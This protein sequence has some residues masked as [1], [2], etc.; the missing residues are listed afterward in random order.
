MI[1]LHHAG[2]I[3]FKPVKFHFNMLELKRPAWSTS[4]IDIKGFVEVVEPWSNLVLQLRVINLAEAEVERNEI[5][6]HNDN[7]LKLLVKQ[8]E[9][10]NK[11]LITQNF[12]G[13]KALTMYD[14]A[15][16]V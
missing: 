3:N 5:L 1:H 11:R 12:F 10:H 2:H 13:F 16:Y 14:S 9:I 8:S 15:I 4:I 7:N 6:L